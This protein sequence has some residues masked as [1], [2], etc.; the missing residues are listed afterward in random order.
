M[1]TC[2]SRARLGVLLLA[3]VAAFPVFSQTQ[4]P[5]VLKEVVVT[6]T[7]F[8]EPAGTLPFGVSVITSEEI[9]SS[10]ATSVNEA[11]MRLLGVPGRL[12]LSGGNN[13]SLDLRGFG[14]TADSNQIVVV[15]GLRFNEADQATAG[16]SS[17]PIDSVERIEVLRGTGSV[18]YGEGATGGVIVITTKAGLGIQRTNSAQL[19]G[20]IG[21]HN[22][23]DARASVLLT[24]GGFSMDVVADDRRTDGHRDNFASVSNGLNVSGQW[25]NDWLRMG[26]RAGR[27]SLGSGLPGALSAAA[28]AADPYQADPSRATSKTDSA[29]IKKENTGLFVEASM[30]SWQL[31]ADANQRSKVLHSFSYADPFDYDVDASN[32]SMRALHNGKIASN[33]NAFVIGYDQDAWD[34]TIKQST[35]TPVGSRAAAKSSAFYIKDDL[36]F[37]AA[38]TRVSVGWRTQEM[39]KAEGNS[40]TSLNDRLHAWDLGVSQPIQ[41][42]ITVYGRL[43]SSFRLPNV[44]EFSFATPGVPLK[45]QTSR[46][47]E[48]GARWKLPSG[49][50]E[51]RLYRNELTNEIGYDSNAI[52]PHSYDSP[53]PSDGANVNFDPT[54]R[55]GLELETKQALRASLDLRVNVALRQ[56]KFIAGV[57]SGNDVALVPKQTLAVRAN[58]RPIAGHSLDGGVTWVSEQ[59]P[60]FANACK[61]PSYAILDLRYAYKY[62]NAEFA[63]GV[64][65]LTNE[66]YYTLAYACAGSLPTYVYPEAG[67]NFTASVR[68]KF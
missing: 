66:K 26:A 5:P 4:T 16:L 3:L 21:S 67:R 37:S 17:I 59:S 29:S 68:L 15:D 14:V 28:Y 19:Y 52:G 13:Y 39:K 62:Q 33:A 12:D 45:A 8:A 34:R 30:G 47:L 56:A 23:K 31:A 32:Y 1:K 9:Q 58:W 50:V 54:Q 40:V 35:F 27:N 22:L 49:Q 38:G 6:A 55:Q 10:G 46:D 42:N 51:M 43:G 61:M 57:Y 24:S 25:S 48:L 64:A 60:D 18:L 44:D 63:L 2:F 36:T 11:V 65:N 53:Y 20:A 41:Q 7:R